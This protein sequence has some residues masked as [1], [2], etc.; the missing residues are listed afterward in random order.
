V[1]FDLNLARAER[2]AVMAAAE[3]G[4]LPRSRKLRFDTVAGWRCARF[5]SKLAV[6]ECPRTL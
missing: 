4:A 3:S 1:G 5:E 6:G 2:E